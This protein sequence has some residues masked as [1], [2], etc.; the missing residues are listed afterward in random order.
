[1][2]TQK[3]ITMPYLTMKSKKELKIKIKMKKSKEFYSSFFFKVKS[4][5][6]IPLKNI[7]KKEN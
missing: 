2:E 6:K 3:R 1:M 5:E 4:R 7:I